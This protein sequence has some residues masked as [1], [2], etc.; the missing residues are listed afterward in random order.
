MEPAPVTG[1]GDGASAAF[2]MPK[3]ANIRTTAYAAATANVEVF[4]AI[5]VTGYETGENQSKAE[6]R[7]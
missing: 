1:L 5:V 4:I 6:S 2:A 7:H 3:R